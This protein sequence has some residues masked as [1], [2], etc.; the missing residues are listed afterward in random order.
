MSRITERSCVAPLGMFSQA[1]S[2]SAG[3]GTV[4]ASF[5]TYTGQKFDTSDGR[6]LTLVSV[7]TTLIPSGVLVS[8]VAP[9][10]GHQTLTVAAAVAIGGTT[11][12]VTNSTT[13]VNINQYQGGFL[14]VK[15]GTGAGQTLKI[16]TNSAAANAG[17]ITVVTE[18]AVVTALATDSIVN[19]IPSPYNN[20]VIE[21]HSTL[22]GNIVGVTLYPL[23]AS[24]ANTYNA[25]TGLQTATGVAQY[26]YIVSK[27]VTSCL[28]DA[29]VAAIGL[30]IMP[31]TST[32]GA[33]TVIT[34]TGAQVGRSLQLG[35]SGKYSAVYIDC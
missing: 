28:S 15:D 35:V 29:T 4:D 7:G 13:V 11:I 1:T 5:S 3:T 8:G 34:A 9:V 14:V 31:S 26:G 22:P 12:T 10:A 2:T 24:V 16:Q 23:A 30:G 32:D 25:T 21:N 6:E 27:G 17:L 18:D 20:I 33:I 19:F